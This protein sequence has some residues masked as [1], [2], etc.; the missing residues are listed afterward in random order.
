M[1]Y[2]GSAHIPL[3]AC[4]PGF[5]AGTI[6]RTPVNTWD[7][8]ATILEATGVVVPED[9]PL[10]GV[11]LSGPKMDDADRVI[12]FHHAEGRRRYVAAV[13]LGH[14]FVHW[15]NGGDEELYDLEAD[16]W[17]QRDLMAAG[18]GGHVDVADRLRAACL[19]FERDHGVAANVSGDAFVDLPYEAPPVH[20]CSLYPEWSYRQFPHWM[21]GYSQEDLEAIADQMRAC[22][23]S[24]SF[25]LPIDP[26]W[27]AAAIAAWRQIGGDLAVYQELFAEVD[28]R[29][30]DE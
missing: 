22:L 25:N 17:E 8:A 14:K 21:N 27:R 16:P 4:G 15:F 5:G 28:A 26:T 9:H 2:E 23:Q 20:T 7:I 6:C 1:P 30:R 18:G 10:L 12:V 19:A 11:S 24:D 29:P 13:G 3:I